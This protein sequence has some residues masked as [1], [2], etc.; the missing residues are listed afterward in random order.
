ME[1]YACRTN[2]T[3]NESSSL[4][5]KCIFPPNPQSGYTDIAQKTLQLSFIKR[6]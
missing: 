3:T 2:R 6:L 1:S 5:S 4:D